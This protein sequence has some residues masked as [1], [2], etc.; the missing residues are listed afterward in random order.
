M[1]LKVSFTYESLFI[2]QQTQ[3]VQERRKVAFEI[4]LLLSGDIELC[5]G[6]VNQRSIPGLVNLLG[7]KGMNILHQNVRGL[8]GNKDYI[9]EIL[10]SFKNINILC[11]S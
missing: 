7:Q 10:E 6:P 9:L 5:P 8:F 1:D 11:N 2:I 3:A 4:L